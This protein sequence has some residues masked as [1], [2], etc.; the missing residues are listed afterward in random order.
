MDAAHPAAIRSRD[1]LVRVNRLMGNAYWIARAVIQAGHSPRS[2]AE[3]GGGDG[4]FLLSLVRR[5]HTRSIRPSS[6]ALLDKQSIVS[7]TTFAQFKGLDCP[8]Q[9]VSA[10]I[11]NPSA[12]LPF[13]D[14]IICNLFLHHFEGAAL[15]NILARASAQCDLFIACEPRRWRLAPYTTPL[16]GLI[17]CNYVTRHDAKRSV[18]AGFWDGELST[19]WPDHKTWTLQEG[20]AGPFSHLFLAK[21][22]TA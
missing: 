11:L 17:G 18:K 12:P 22:V 21:R 4:R 19:A 8:L 6:A 10:D 14:L 1:D 3:W 13:A 2:L 7:A 15:R 20:A 16:L 5:F 9:L